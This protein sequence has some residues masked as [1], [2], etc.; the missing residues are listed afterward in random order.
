MS[1]SISYNIVRRMGSHFTV[2]LKFNID[3]QLYITIT[4][5]HHGH[6]LHHWNYYHACGTLIASYNAIIIEAN[7]GVDY[8]Q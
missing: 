4:V 8:F 2:F 6:S 3:G 7:K 1:Y 5:R